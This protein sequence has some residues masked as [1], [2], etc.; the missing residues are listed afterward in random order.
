MNEVDVFDRTWDDYLKPLKAKVRERAMVRAQGDSRQEIDLPDAVEAI[1]EYVGTKND[2]SPNRAEGWFHKN[3]SGFIGIVAVLAV[4]FGILGTLPQTKDAASGL[5]E[6]AKML[7]GALVGG[8]AGAA[9]TGGTR[10]P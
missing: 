10:R 2:G 1:Q 5:F 6:I 7:A 8:A 9:A 4:I 3:V